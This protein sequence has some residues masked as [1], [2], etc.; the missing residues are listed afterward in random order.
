MKKEQIISIKQ[1]EK[2]IILEYLIMKC[3]ECP[4]HWYIPVDESSGSGGG[5]S[6]CNLS[7]KKILNEKEKFPQ[8]CPL[9]K[10]TKL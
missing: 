3:I 6:I 8:W 2:G 10:E 7:N 5:Y 1:T 4:F 9:L